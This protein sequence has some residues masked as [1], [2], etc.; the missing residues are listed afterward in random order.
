MIIR[1]ALAAV[2]VALIFLIAIN[3]RGDKPTK[4]YLMVIEVLGVIIP[5]VII[6]V[7]TFLGVLL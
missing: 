4:K 6:V 2:L 5:L 7:C 1:T 3:I